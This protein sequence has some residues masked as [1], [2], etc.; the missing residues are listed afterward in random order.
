MTLV[1]YTPADLHVARAQ[2]TS[3]ISSVGIDDSDR[4]SFSVRIQQQRDGPC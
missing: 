2:L 4:K 3:K 1:M